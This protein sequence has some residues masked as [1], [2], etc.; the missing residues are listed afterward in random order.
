MEYTKI[1]NMDIPDK[2]KKDLKSKVKLS[3]YIGETSRST[4]ERG[5]EHL[6]D[7]TTLSSKS[8]MLKHILTDHP[9]ENI[10]NIKFGI[11]IIRNCRTSFERQIYESVAIQQAREQNIELTI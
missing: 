7:L 5:W 10:K 4:F 1:E 3:I 8:H 2:E 6:N 9:D 11:R